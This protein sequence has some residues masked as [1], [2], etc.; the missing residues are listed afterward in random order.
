MSFRSPL[1]PCITENDACVEQSSSGTKINQERT[2]PRY[3]GSTGAVIHGD[4]LPQEHCSLAAV[5]YSIL[6][7]PDPSSD[8]QE[9]LSSVICITSIVCR[10]QVYCSL[11]SVFMA[12]EELTRRLAL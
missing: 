9:T 12:G 2:E 6:Q 5:R 4:V 1:S 10:P 11:P 8:P 7:R 3:L